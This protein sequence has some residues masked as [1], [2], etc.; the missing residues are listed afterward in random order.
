MKAGIKE[1]VSWVFMI[2][3]GNVN[4]MKMKGGHCR[5]HQSDWM[6]APYNCLQ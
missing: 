2:T 6:A 1:Q 5:L 4:V 3:Q